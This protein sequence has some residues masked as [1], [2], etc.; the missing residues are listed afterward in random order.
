[1][2]CQRF[3]ELQLGGSQVAVVAPQGRWDGS[4]PP[5]ACEEHQRQ[6]VSVAA[7]GRHLAAVALLQAS[8]AA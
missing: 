1:M 6:G 2:A 8:A 7:L 4:V 3:Q 5:R